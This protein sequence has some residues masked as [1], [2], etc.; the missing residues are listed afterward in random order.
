MFSYNWGPNGDYDDVEGYTVV[1]LYCT[2]VLRDSET[3]PQRRVYY[4]EGE[5]PPPYNVVYVQSTDYYYDRPPPD[6]VVYRQPAP[7]VWV[8]IMLLLL[9]D[10]SLRTGAHGD[11]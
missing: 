6:T 4:I 3:Q 9:N 5:P 8:I 11:G 10:R 2:V 7:S 1:R